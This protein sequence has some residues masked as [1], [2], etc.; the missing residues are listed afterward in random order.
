MATA[1]TSAQENHLYSQALTV[2]G[3]Q[4][5]LAPGSWEVDAFGGTLPP[6]LLLN[7]TTGVISGTPTA[8]SAKT[9]SFTII[10]EDAVGTACSKDYSIR[11][12]PDPFQSIVWTTGTQLNNGVTCEAEGAEDTA[13]VYSLAKPLAGSQPIAFAYGFL[14]ATSLPLAIPCKA[15]FVISNIA[16]YVN[17]N[18][19]LV[20]LKNSLGVYSVIAPVVGPELG[21][22][23]IHGPYNYAFTIPAGNSA[24]TFQIRSGVSGG[25][26]SYSSSTQIHLL[27]EVL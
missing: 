27:L 24:W 3:A 2:V 18:T 7:T 19:W 14:T 20:V 10:L 26:P 8:G 5:P 11:V 17:Q 4:G 12:R 1:L 21:L 15:N 23:L 22:G 25:P 13:R 16:Y 6:G 9:Y